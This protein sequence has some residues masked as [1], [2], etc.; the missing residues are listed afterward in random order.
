MKQATTT[1]QSW[2]RIRGVELLVHLGTESEERE[3]QQI[4]NLDI[5]VNFTTAPI[6][7]ETDNLADTF[8]YAE[9]ITAL[10]DHVQDREYHLIEKLTAELYKL[11]KNNLNQ[12]FHTTDVMVKLT[13][14]PNV[15]G[16]TGGV[17]FNYG[18][19]IA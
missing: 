16:L 15:E 19:E 2:L 14:H 7:C 3:Q 10:R 6:A 4:V 12:Q 13:K 18:D 11:C 8:C 5:D 1:I 9:L 17:T